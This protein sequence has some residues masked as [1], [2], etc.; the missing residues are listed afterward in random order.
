[1]VCPW[2]RV[3]DTAAGAAQDPVCAFT[4]VDF[5][6]SLTP[7]EIVLS[8]RTLECI[9]SSMSLQHIGVGAPGDGVWLQ[10]ADDETAQT[11]LAVNRDGV[12]Q[13]RHGREV[14]VLATLQC[15]VHIERL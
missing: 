8:S 10:V 5:I 2:P 14:Q 3:K 6:S 7:G 11:A 1:M 4:A 13:G 15:H 12:V 9:V